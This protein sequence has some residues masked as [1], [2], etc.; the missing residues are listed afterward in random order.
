[1]KLATELSYIITSYPDGLKSA[2]MSMQR[3][4]D[5]QSSSRWTIWKN[6]TRSTRRR[7]LTSWQDKEED[8]VSAMDLAVKRKARINI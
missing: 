5:G 6:E 7:V 3:P 1:M 4:D 8:G 2:K